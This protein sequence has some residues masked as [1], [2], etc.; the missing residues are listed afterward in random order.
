MQYLICHVNNRPFCLGEV[1]QQLHK[2][3]HPVVLC[4]GDHFQDSVG[5][6]LDDFLI[7]QGFFQLLSFLLDI[8]QGKGVANRI[9]QLEF[10][11]AVG[12]IDLFASIQGC[13]DIEIHY[14]LL[15]DDLGEVMVVVGLDNH[16][17]GE[18]FW[19]AVF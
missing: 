8:S 11:I 14:F 5:Q 17:P 4:D 3:L 19:R 2:H 16:V 1:V 7:V 15:M 6:Q 9:N 18:S 13:Q 10:G 12:N